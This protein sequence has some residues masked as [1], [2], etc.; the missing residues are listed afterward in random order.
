MRTLFKSVI[1]IVSDVFGIMTV[2]LLRTIE[3]VSALVLLFKIMSFRVLYQ[4]PNEIIDMT[5]GKPLQLKAKMKILCFSVPL[6]EFCKHR[7]LFL[8]TPVIYK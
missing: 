5:G 7:L 4:L 2:I 1:Y 8:I 6:K 3:F